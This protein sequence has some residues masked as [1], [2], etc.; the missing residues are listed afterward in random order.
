[1]D[2]ILK[3]IKDDYIVS[4]S[5]SFREKTSKLVDKVTSPIVGTYYAF[6]LFGDI[7]GD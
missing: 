5:Y 4:V 6:K 2:K 3:I 1:M 7:F